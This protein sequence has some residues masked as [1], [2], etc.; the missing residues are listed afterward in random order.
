MALETADFDGLLVVAMI[1]ASAFAE[2]VHGADAG[3]AGAENVCVE[4]GERGAAQITLRDF[5]D[6]TRYI[7]V[8]GASGDTRGVETVEAAVGFGKCGLVV[9]GRMEIREASGQF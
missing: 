2:N 6:E 3:T 1:D 4:N 9:E 5:F 8:R 7:N